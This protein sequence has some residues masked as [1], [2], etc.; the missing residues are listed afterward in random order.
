MA[1]YSIEGYFRELPPEAQTSLACVKKLELNVTD[2]DEI[3]KLNNIFNQYRTQHPSWVSPKRSGG[4]DAYG[5]FLK[6]NTAGL[7]LKTGAASLRLPL[8]KWLNR[9][10]IVRFSIKPYRFFNQQGVMIIGGSAQL[11]GLEFSVLDP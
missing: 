2:R 4:N 8:D 9:P 11:Q 10:V 5:I 3:Q 6:L 1:M 7:L